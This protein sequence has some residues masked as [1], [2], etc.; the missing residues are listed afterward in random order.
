MQ[1][2]RG[3]LRALA[4]NLAQL[5]LAASLLPSWEEALTLAREL[6]QLHSLDLSANRMAFPAAATAACFG[7]LRTLVL[8][9]CCIGWE[10]VCCRSPCMCR[11]KASHDIGCAVFSVR[12]NPRSTSL[13]QVL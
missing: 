5:D 1:G 3:A 11:D 6:P 4:P 12:G 2:P 8:N 10:Q 13:P 7:S 9:Q